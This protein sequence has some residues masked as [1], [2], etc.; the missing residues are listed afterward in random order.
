MSTGNVMQWFC[1]V[2]YECSFL[3]Y[4]HFSCPLL[5]RHD[6]AFDY[7]SYVSYMIS[8]PK[9]KDVVYS[10]RVDKISSASC[11]SGKHRRVRDSGAVVEQTEGK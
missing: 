5:E 2:I 7:F 10:I 3:N 4:R 9:N 6:W 11:A 8:S 1:Q